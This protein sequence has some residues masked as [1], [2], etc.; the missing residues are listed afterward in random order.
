MCRI[1]RSQNRAG[2]LRTASFLHW[3]HPESP[4]QCA[5]DNM[6]RHPSYCSGFNLWL[7]QLPNNLAPL[8]GFHLSCWNRPKVASTNSILTGEATPLISWQGEL[9]SIL[10]KKEDI[11]LSNSLILGYLS[12]FPR[13]YPV[14]CFAP[15]HS[16]CGSKTATEW[17]SCRWLPQPRPHTHGP[18]ENNIFKLQPPVC[19]HLKTGAIMLDLTML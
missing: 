6:R 3:W 7:R 19:L 2:E 8:M 15:A 17:L 13:Q 11:L 1:P 5:R 9:I 14:F 16:N 4:P 12:K 18:D 10:L